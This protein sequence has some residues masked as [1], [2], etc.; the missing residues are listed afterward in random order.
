MNRMLSNGRMIPALG[1]GSFHATQADVELA[2]AM[3]YRM[4]DTAAFYGNERAIG[5]AIRNCGL[6]REEIFVTTKLWNTNQG[7][8]NATI[9]FNESRRKLG[10]EYVDLYLIHWPA[11]R[12]DLYRESWKALIDIA[13]AGGAKSIGVCNFGER[14]IAELID[15]T[16]C[17]PVVNQVEIH[18][19]FAQQDLK[20]FH[21]RLGIVTMAWGPLGQGKG[22]L[23]QSEIVQLAMALGRTAAQVVLRWHIQLGNIPIPKSSNESRMSEN[24]RVFDFELDTSQMSTLTRFPGQS[25]LGPDPERFSGRKLFIPND[26]GSSD[27]AAGQ[28]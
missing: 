6:R 26:D 24:L 25:R 17:T 4:L 20:A 8:E 7:Y 9:A 18:P 1:F 23:D 3:G 16:G 28:L 15:E 2:L 27:T 14:E 19:G 13:Q 5:A 22:L 21:D 10:L 11:P 12:I